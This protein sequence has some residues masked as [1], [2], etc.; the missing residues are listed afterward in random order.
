MEQS[1]EHNKRKWSK[2][3]SN[4]FD[5]ML[6]WKL[7]RECILTLKGQVVPHIDYSIIT[8]YLG[9][10]SSI[11]LEILKKYLLSTTCIVMSVTAT[12]YFVTNDKKGLT[13]SR[14]YIVNALSTSSAT[15]Y[16]THLLNIQGRIVEYFNYNFVRTQH[17]LSHKWFICVNGASVKGYRHSG[18]DRKN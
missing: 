14:K 7:Y 2:Y 5:I 8:T 11:F 3:K 17:I 13:T 18:R 9:N 1:I 10:I 16:W 15:I 4:V 12:L 6:F